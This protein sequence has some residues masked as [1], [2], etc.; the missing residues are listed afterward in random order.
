MSPAFRIFDNHQH[1]G[2]VAGV[3]G[4][5]A[6]NVVSEDEIAADHRVRSAVMDRLGIA[7]AA[8]MPGHMYIRPRGLADTRAVNDALAAFRRLDP[9]R[10]PAVIG[11]VEP[12]YGD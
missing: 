3:A 7:Q 1:V 11:T 9:E 5:H 12:R 8:L 2:G 10:F 6:G 4:H